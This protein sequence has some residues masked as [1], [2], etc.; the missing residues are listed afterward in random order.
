MMRARGLLDGAVVEYERA[1]AVGGSDA[2]LAGKLA[3]TLLDLGKADRAAELAAPLVAADE[4]DV[5]AA[6][7]LGLARAAESKWAEA[8]AAFELALRVSPFDPAVR[9]GLAEAYSKTAHAHADR[10]RSACDTL[11]PT[12]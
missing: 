11:I 1:I 4:S 2:Y 9:C 10:E 3:R 6:V 8:A 5:V 7:T 12:P